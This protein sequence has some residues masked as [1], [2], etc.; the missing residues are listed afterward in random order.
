MKLVVVIP[1]YNEEKKIGDVLNAVPRR[2][3]G[4]QRTEVVVVDDGSSDHTA[5]IARKYRATVLSHPVNLGLGGA[6]GTGLTYAREHGA[7]I[8]ITL[9][10]DGQHDPKE[11]PKLIRPII[12]GRADFVVGTR[13]RT[14][15]GMPWYR[16]VGNW[17]LNLF[18]YLMYGVWSTDSQSGFRAF[19]R[20]ALKKLEVDLIGM[21]ASSG[22]FDAVAV[23][24]LRYTEVP[25]R[26]IYT[27]YSLTKG[28]RNWNAFTILFRLFYNKFLK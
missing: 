15:N 16:V 21:E 5:S 10:A 19:S 17:G 26:P 25:I 11:A 6:L 12:G 3:P 4:I 18:T 1:A 22:F 14:V 13:L 27:N 2:L 7:D 9:D 24:K 20:R 8:A 28:Q 23:H